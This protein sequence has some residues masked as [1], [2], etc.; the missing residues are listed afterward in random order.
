[1]KTDP[2]AEDDLGKCPY[3]VWRSENFKSRHKGCDLRPPAYYL[4]YGYKYCVRFGTE[5]APKLSPAGKVWLADARY[6]L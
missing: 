2:A 1:M 5:T 4:G 3:Y 6:L